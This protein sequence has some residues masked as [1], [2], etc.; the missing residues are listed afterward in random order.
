MKTL[1]DHGTYPAIAT[2]DERI[3]GEAFRYARERR[4]APERFEFQMLYG[5]R[6]DLQRRIVDL[7]Y[8]L[9]L[10][11]PYGAAWY[12]YFMRRLAERPA[13]VWFLLRN[14]LR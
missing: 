4:L 3:I 5:I 10:Y 9:R 14:L 6:R 12:P 11:V 7:G 2:H 8:R 1:L 13:N